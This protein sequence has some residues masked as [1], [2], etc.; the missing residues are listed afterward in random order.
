M[1][2]NGARRLVQFTALSCL[3]SLN[4]SCGE[5]GA[6]AVPRNALVVVSGDGQRT[7]PGAQ[8]PRPLVVRAVGPD[9]NPL[10][11]ILVR[12]SGSAGSEFEH[13]EGLHFVTNADGLASKAWVVGYT[14]GTSSHTAIARADGLTHATFAAE[15]A[16]GA[17]ELSVVPDPVR[18]YG[19][20]DTA[21]IWLRVRSP[22][23]Q[24][25][26][27]VT[28][29]SGGSTPGRVA[30]PLPSQGGRLLRAIKLGSHQQFVGYGNHNVL[31]TIIV[32]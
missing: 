5:P 28:P 15:A 11:G 13:H 31:F 21:R 26:T 22:S 32:E 4:S 27:L 2:A 7:L 30:E 16:E 23:V 14:T 24:L 12:W 20:G 9:G 19:I 6:P 1:T 29:L 3:A 10:A 8:I 17:L 25:D 18:L